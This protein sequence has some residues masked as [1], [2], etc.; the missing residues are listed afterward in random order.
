MDDFTAIP[1]IYEYTVIRLV[2]GF[3]PSETHTCIISP[4]VSG[5]LKR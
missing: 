4:P 3:T 5:V 2:E 1:K